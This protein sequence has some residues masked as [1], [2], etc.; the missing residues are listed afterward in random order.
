M[1]IRPFLEHAVALLVRSRPAWIALGLCLCLTP[2]AYANES[3]SPERT[4]YFAA[5]PT[6]WTHPRKVVQP[7]YPAAELAQGV[8]GYVD[9]RVSIS[10]SGAYK[11]V[12]SMTSTPAVP[13]FEAAVA[14]AVQHW[15]YKPTFNLNCKHIEAEGT[16]RVWFEIKDGKPST[17]VSQ[18]QKPLPG[19]L[20]YART[21]NIKEVAET[22]RRSSRGQISQDSVEVSVQ[23]M[24]TVDAAT[25]KALD[26]KLTSIH[27][28]KEGTEAYGES[29]RLGLLASRF[30]KV[31]PEKEGTV[32]VCNYFA[33]TFRQGM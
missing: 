23:A 7:T 26:A 14:E 10:D 33:V 24:L 3:K 31:W 12:I 27:T 30:D 2:A 17:R 5:N 4:F 18:L 28:S 32:S 9:V 16:N 8:T 25:G 13:A 6:E 22:I 29:I 20:R 11:G 1:D 19:N 15:F 21:T